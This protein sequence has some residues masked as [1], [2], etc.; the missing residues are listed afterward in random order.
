MDFEMPVGYKSDSISYYFIEDLIPNH[1]INWS[2]GSIQS[3]EDFD[4]KY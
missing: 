4:L 2:P 1:F 3:C